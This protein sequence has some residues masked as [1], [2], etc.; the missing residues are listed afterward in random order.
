VSIVGS[1]QA[2]DFQGL[3]LSFPSSSGTYLEILQTD[4]NIV[5]Y[6]SQVEMA[7]R[8]RKM[9]L[10]KRWRLRKVESEQPCHVHIESVAV[11]LFLKICHR[12]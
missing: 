11:A 6:F 2:A 9:M 8:I 12:I 10:M 3:C 7:K 4:C 5:I 1:L